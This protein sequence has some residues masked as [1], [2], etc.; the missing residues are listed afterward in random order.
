VRV[1]ISKSPSAEHMN[2]ERKYVNW[3]A[4]VAGKWLDVE[5]KHLFQDQYNTSGGRVFDDQIDA[6][7]DDA[8]AGRV[9]CHWCGGQFGVEAVID[10]AAA[11]K[12]IDARGIGEPDPEAKK[13]LVEAKKSMAEQPAESEYCPLCLRGGHILDLMKISNLYDRVW[14]F[15]Q[16]PNPLTLKP[17]QDYIE[18]EFNPIY[19]IQNLREKIIPLVARRNDAPADQVKAAQ[20]MYME[21]VY[22]PRRGEIMEDRKG[23][24]QFGRALLG[25]VDRYG[26]VVEGTQGETRVEHKWC[27]VCGKE[28]DAGGLVVLTAKQLKELPAGRK[29]SHTILTGSGLCPEHQGRFDEGYVAVVAIDITKSDNPPTPSGARRTGGVALVRREALKRIFDVDIPDDTPLIFSEE[30]VIGKLAELASHAQ[31]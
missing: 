14:E 13:K 10:K 26:D 2:S 16:Y 3:I 23:W 30:E 28:Y 29:N 6:I 4:S 15:I 21:E 18:G 25:K 31:S 9:S 11:K 19:H 5:T 12:E 22:G 8:R 17:I 20:D 24:E 27:V 7:E 1:K